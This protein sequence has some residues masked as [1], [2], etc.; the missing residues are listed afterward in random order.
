[1]ASLL[2]S[3]PGSS[4]YC[5]GGLS[6]SKDWADT[7]VQGPGPQHSMQCLVAVCG[8]NERTGFSIRSLALPL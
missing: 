8:M 1:M 5:S 2:V 4:S 6:G 3:A 7:E